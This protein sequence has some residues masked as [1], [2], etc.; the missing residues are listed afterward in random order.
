MWK[1]YF[2]TQKPKCKTHSHKWRQREYLSSSATD[3]ELVHLTLST[4]LFK[5]N[6][7]AETTVAEKAPS[8]E[9]KKKKKKKK[10]TKQKVQAGNATDNDD[11]TSTAVGT[12]YWNYARYYISYYIVDLF[13]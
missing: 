3:S 4:C 2:T 5:R 10:K 7:S 12:L 11:D 1:V 6:D 9:K 13:P 8:S